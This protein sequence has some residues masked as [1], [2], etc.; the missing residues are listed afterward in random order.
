M[1]RTVVEGVDCV[2]GAVAHVGEPTRNERFAL[3]SDMDVAGG[4]PSFLSGRKSFA[5]SFTV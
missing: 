3:F 5:L 4:N 2:V 1:P